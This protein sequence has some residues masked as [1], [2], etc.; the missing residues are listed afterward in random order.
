MKF[1]GY[2]REDGSAG[3]R[4]FLVV[5]PSVFCANKVAEQIAA[6]IEDA[7]SLTHSVG[8][9]QVGE[10][11][12]QT[13]RTLKNLATHPNVGGVLIVGLGCER[14]TPQ[15]FYDAVKESGKPVEKVVIQEEGDSLKA[16]TVGTEKLYELNEVVNSYQREEID[17]SELTI[18]LECGGTDAT[19]GIAANPAIGKTSDILISKGGSSV[20]SETTELLGAEHILRR[21]CVDD[22][23]AEKMLNSVERTEGELARATASEKYKHRSALI[24]TGNF[25]GGVSTVVEKAL[26]NIH[27][28]GTAPVTGAV[29]YAEKMQAKGL[30]FMDT[31]GQDG[32][33]TTGLVTGGAQ[34]VL[35]TTGRGTPTGFPIAPVIKITGNDDTFQKMK[36][37]LDINAGKVILGEEDIDS[38]GKIIFEYM[39][40]VASGKKIK[41][42]VLGHDELFN[43][44]R[45]LNYCGS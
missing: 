2:K 17:V 33:S 5:I 43:I 29:K 26:G 45:V 39:L 18:G 6:N 9:S 4:N 14:F 13:A 38:M 32:E 10:D 11:L 36:F 31:P 22:E 37:N 44:P 24:S 19:S 20:F 25:D 28:T 16:V 30:N 7:V 3:V 15:E 23:V 1:M 21:R 12:E 27:K 41:A 34:I 35:F 42:E 8:C 40:E